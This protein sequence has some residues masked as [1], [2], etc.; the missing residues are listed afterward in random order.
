MA[1]RAT[2]FVL[3][4]DDLLSAVVRYGQWLESQG[5]R[6][7]VEPSDLEYPTTP[8][9]RGYRNAGEDYFY[10]VSSVVDLKRAEEWAKYGRASQRDTRFVVAIAG[11]K[12]VSTATLSK[13]AE[14]KVGLDVIADTTVSSLSAPHDLSLNVD[15]PALPAGLRKTLG[16]AKDLWSR[17]EWKEAYEDACVALAT[18]ACEYLQKAVKAQ[19]VTFVSA[20]GKSIK[21]TQA[22]IGKMTLGQLEHAFAEIT[23]PTQIESRAT[24]AMARINPRRVTV[25][26]FKHKSGK[27]LQDLRG[28]VG[29]D[30]IVIVNIMTMLK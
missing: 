15:F 21:Y 4:P 8:V 14:L 23:A 9:F 27:R 28:K 5:Y 18:R 22:K 26:H 12:P 17:G 20:N 13:L 11:S 1:I 30:L 10:E 3:V 25:A 2:D 16:H 29:K 6:L 7:T 24:Q 19:R